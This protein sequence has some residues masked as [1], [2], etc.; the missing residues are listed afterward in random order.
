MYCSVAKI[1]TMNVPVPL[2]K[3]V[4]ISLG[5]NRKNNK[6]K[7]KLL[8]CNTV[9]SPDLFYVTKMR[10]IYFL[11]AFDLMLAASNVQCLTFRLVLMMHRCH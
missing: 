11:F 6:N 3:T 8:G 1:T 2:L 9:V 4:K 7:K 10:Q 5:E